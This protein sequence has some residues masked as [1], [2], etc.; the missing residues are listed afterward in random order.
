MLIFSSTYTFSK[1]GISH[2]NSAFYVLAFFKWK[3]S[4]PLERGKQPLFVPTFIFHSLFTFQLPNGAQLSNKF[5]ELLY[6]RLLPVLEVVKKTLPGHAYAIFMTLSLYSWGT[7]C[8]GI[9]YEWQLEGDELFFLVVCLRFQPNL[10]QFLPEQ[11]SPFFDLCIIY[12]L[13]RRI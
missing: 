12:I 5:W 1:C 2:A 11:D 6:K 4:L 3:N 10:L 9:F 7:W 8:F 13:D